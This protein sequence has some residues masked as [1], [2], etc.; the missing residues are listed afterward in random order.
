MKIIA[1]Q[2]HAR[3]RALVLE[4]AREGGRERGGE[5]ER[6]RGR[7]QRRC[8]RGRERE[9]EGGWV[10]GSGKEGGTEGSYVSV[11]TPLPP[12]AG[13][14]VLSVGVF[15]FRRRDIHYEF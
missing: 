5:G 4:E 13:S 12:E 7:I 9:G 6:E 10:G 1:D 14:L 2:K 11:R 15:Y 3:S 8:V